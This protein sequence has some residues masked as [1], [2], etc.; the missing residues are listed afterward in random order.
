MAQSGVFGLDINNLGSDETVSCS[1]STWYVL[2]VTR[3]SGTFTVRAIPFGSGTVSSSSGTAISTAIDS[4]TGYFF[5]TGSDLNF[6]L[7]GGAAIGDALFL[8]GEAV[9]NADLISIAQNSSPLEDFAWFSSREFHLIA[10]EAADNTGNHT[11]STTGSPVIIPG[12]P[13]FIRF[14]LTITVEAGQSSETNTS[15]AFNW[16]KVLDIAQSSETDTSQAVGALKL[17]SLGQS[18]EADTASEF[19]ADTS[20]KLLLQSQENDSADVF[21]KS[22]LLSTGQS[23]ETDSANTFAAEHVVNLIQSSETDVANTF[24]FVKF[25]AIGSTAETDTAVNVTRIGG[26]LPPLTMDNV[27]VKIIARDLIENASV[28]ATSTAAGFSADNIKNDEKFE[29]WRSTDLSTQQITFTWG[30]PQV[31]SALAI[32]FSNL[33]EGSTVN[34]EVFTNAADSEGFAHTGPVSINFAYQ[35]PKGFNSIGYLSFAYGGGTYYSTFFEE[36]T[37]EKVRVTVTSAGN[38]DGYME[39]SKIVAGLATDFVSGANYG[40]S[41]TKV[42]ASEH[43]RTYT[44]DAV[45]NRRGQHKV[46]DVTLGKLTPEDRAA[47]SNMIRGIS[48]DSLVFVSV[49]PDAVSD[50]DKQTY[51][52]YGAFTDQNT[53]VSISHNRNSVTFNIEEF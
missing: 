52:M 26:T 25:L 10:S 9:S 34:V 49:S 31:L 29:I 35:P 8:P 17:Y 39:I 27:G 3:S 24:I 20:T 51:Q 40:A 41:V 13:G 36:Q 4:S 15:Q 30:S 32:I 37:V 19:I 47:N 50:Y 14:T 46:M 48:N 23:S 7:V 38:P 33:I 43:N 12:P 18:T 1:T 42:D 45:V 16:S 11:V 22:K 21:D 6:P 28:T 2:A 53:L 5:G 44:G